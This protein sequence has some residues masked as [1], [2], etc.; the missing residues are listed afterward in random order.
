[1]KYCS[2][3]GSDRISWTI[4]SDDNRPRHVCGACN[5]VFYQNPKIV[6]GC[7][8]VWE[9]QVLLCKRAI[10]PRYG[11][12]TLPAGFMENAETTFEAAERETQEE[13]NADVKD[14]DL[15]TVLNIPH[16]NQV[17]MMFRANLRN[18]DFHPGA[19]SLECKMFTED[20]I[21]W[22]E[23]AFP[24]IHHTLKFF[25]EDRK[26]NQ[27]RMRAGDI[28]WSDGRAQYFDRREA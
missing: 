24:T 14:L 6:T 3:C 22:R 19:E 18:L 21:P 12:W 1:M 8:P 7:I 20:E 25:Y 16:T 26:K 11:Y 4:P 2:N 13:A 28:V 10:E 15:Y 17:Y 9:E 5:T 23:L 27:F